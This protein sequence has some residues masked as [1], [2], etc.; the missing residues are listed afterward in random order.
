MV[1]N[2]ELPRV[3]YYNLFISLVRT[4]RLTVYNDK[5]D[6]IVSNKYW[7]EGYVILICLLC[8]NIFEIYGII[9]L[10]C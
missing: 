2:P 1:V 9:I 10:K 5:V 7:Q 6:V 8:Y 4:S 3:I